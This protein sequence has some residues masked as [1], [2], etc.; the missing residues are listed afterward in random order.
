MFTPNYDLITQAIVDANVSPLAKESGSTLAERWIEKNLAKDIERRVSSVECGLVCWLDE[1]TVVIGV[2]DLLTEEEGGIVGNEHKSTGAKK[3]SDWYDDLVNG[4]QIAIYALALQTGAY[5]E[6]GSNT[7]FYP[8]EPLP[9]VRVRAI[10]KDEP[11]KLWPQDN[12]DLIQFTQA[13][14]DNTKRALLAKAASIRAMRGSGNVPWQLPGIWCTNK[15]RRT[16]EHYSS[17][18]EGK[19]A[20]GYG[21]FDK[22]DPAF[23]LALKHVGPRVED[24]TLVILGASA[25][26]AVSECAEKYRR[27]TLGVGKEESMALDTGTVLHIAV[28]EYYRQLREYQQKENVCP[29]P[30]PLAV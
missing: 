3:E 10:T 16:C 22:H 7:P 21:V 2:Q 24:P 6:K 17:C 9:R 23:E 13:Q 4:S 28:G 11:A 19:H 18:V 15:Y 20:D 14:L 30:A 8:N 29:P 5:Y 27:N 25:Y 1:D 26:A 12:P